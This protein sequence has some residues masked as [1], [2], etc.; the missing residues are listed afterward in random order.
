M[1]CVAHSVPEHRLGATSVA[2]FITKRAGLLRSARS[3]RSFCG[4]RLGGGPSAAEV[5]SLGWYLGRAACDAGYK[6]RRIPLPRTPVNKG[7]KKEGGGFLRAPALSDLALELSVSPTSPCI[8]QPHRLR[9]GV[10]SALREVD[11]P[12]QTLLP[13]RSTPP[14]QPC[15]QRR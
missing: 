8:R 1:Y 2:A 12:P 3:V 11:D 14:Q 4:R 13:Q 9:S 6:R 5:V 10:G 15:A 7:K